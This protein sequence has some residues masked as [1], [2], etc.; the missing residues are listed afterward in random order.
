[1]NKGQCNA[2]EPELLFLT[3]KEV[4]GP[5]IFEHLKFGHV[6]AGQVKPPFTPVD[7]M[8][9]E[10]TLLLVPK[11]YHYYIISKQIYKCTSVN[12]NTLIITQILVAEKKKINKIW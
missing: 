2:N 10:R 3:W 8:M 1:M 7:R 9:N 11:Y 4:A 5:Y 6:L 12:Y